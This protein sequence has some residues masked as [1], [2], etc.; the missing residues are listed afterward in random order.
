MYRY[1][2]TYD[3]SDSVKPTARQ[4]HPLRLFRIDDKVQ[5]F[6]IGLWETRNHDPP[7]LDDEHISAIVNSPTI[8]HTRNCRPSSI[9]PNKGLF[10]DSISYRGHTAPLRSKLAI[11]GLSGETTCWFRAR[12]T[13][14]QITAI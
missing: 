2:N 1:D 9:G 4:G 14:I 5:V 11:F 13:M 12:T 8:I 10:N 7:Q 6:H 3:S